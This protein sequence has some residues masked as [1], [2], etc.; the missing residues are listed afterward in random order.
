[1]V[2]EDGSMKATDGEFTGI[3]YATGG[4]IGNLDITSLE[5]SSYQVAI[6]SDTGTVFKNGVGIKILTARLYKG[7]DEIT[8][9]ITGYQWYR[10][11]VIL[12]GENK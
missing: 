7:K 5:E 1:M 12:E 8:E 3:I 4:K 2:Y 6:E 10:F 11:D 9:G